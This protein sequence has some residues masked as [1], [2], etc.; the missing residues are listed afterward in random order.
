MPVT[1]VWE[2][3]VYLEVMPM[4]SAV[5]AGLALVA[6]T[7]SS[8]PVLAAPPPRVEWVAAPQCERPAGADL[9]VLEAL[10][11]AAPSA[12]KDVP[13][14]FAWRAGEERQA[15]IERLHE[16]VVDAAPSTFIGVFSDHLRRHII[17]VVDPL[18]AN[19]QQ[20]LSPIRAAVS[21]T[22]LRVIVRPG[23][24]PLA[25]LEA[26]RAE[27][28]T[29]DWAPTDLQNYGFMIDPAASRVV[30]QLPSDATAVAEA[31]LNRFGE[32]VEIQFFTTEGGLQGRMNDGSP[33]YGGAAIGPAS[34]PTCTAGF[35]MDK[36]GG[37]WM[38]SAAHCAM[39]AGGYTGTT[40]HSGGPTFYGYRFT[41]NTW[42]GTHQDMMLLGSHNDLYSRIIHVDPCCPSTRLVTARS[43]PSTSTFVCISGMVSKAK[44]SVD[45]ISTNWSGTM[46]GK[47]YRNMV[48]AFRGDVTISQEGDSGAPIYTRI[49]GGSARIRGMHIG[50]PFSS[51]HVTV[52]FKVSTIESVTGAV[53]ATTCC[54]APSY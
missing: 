13:A 4:R 40:W 44:C 16:Q 2:H 53:T 38:V 46:S 3:S 34:T 10:M 52:F 23:C 26:V 5:F 51:R 6:Q 42:W 35:A 21:G 22:D 11:A 48:Y 43:D 19:P 36:N 28:E 49:G 29:R 9:N 1:L 8:M 18:A 31:L 47:A 24:F 15:A 45:V 30:V 17:V 20:V 12:D 50:D 32:L 7:V 14:L 27:L 54:N 39:A 25:D 41:S 33:H 37:R